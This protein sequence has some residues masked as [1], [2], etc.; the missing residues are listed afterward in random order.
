[1]LIVQ[2]AVLTT[3]E[4]REFTVESNPRNVIQI[5]PNFHIPHS[6]SQGY[7]EAL[8]SV[9]KPREPLIKVNPLEGGGVTGTAPAGRHSVTFLA[10]G[11]VR[12]SVLRIHCKTWTVRRTFMLHTGG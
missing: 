9:T 4:V 5:S 11:L 8:L 10:F 12:A 6:T 1:M 7:S 2:K 3:K